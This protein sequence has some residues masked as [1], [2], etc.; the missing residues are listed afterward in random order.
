MDITSISEG[1]G[2]SACKNNSEVSFNFLLVLIL[3][4]GFASCY[5][6][7]LARLQNC[8]LHSSAEGPSQLPAVSVSRAPKIHPTLPPS[9]HRLQQLRS[10]LQPQITVLASPL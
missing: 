3:S 4:R 7:F 9:I 2:R 10:S 8:F 5:F 1:G 6:H